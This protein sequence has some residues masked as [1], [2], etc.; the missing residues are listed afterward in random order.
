M[1]PGFNTLKEIRAGNSV[2]AAA[3]AAAAGSRQQ[4][5]GGVRPNKNKRK[6]MISVNQDLILVPV[7]AAALA[8]E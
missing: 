3:A 7:H 5:C 6:M 8:S 1:K 4:E 2:H